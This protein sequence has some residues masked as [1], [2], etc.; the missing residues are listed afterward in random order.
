MDQEG[1]SDK[2]DPFER[3]IRY[4]TRQHKNCINILDTN[5]DF[6]S[7]LSLLAAIKTKEQTKTVLPKPPPA[8]SL[9]SQ[10]KLGPS[11]GYSR[12]D[13]EV[14][15]TAEDLFNIQTGMSFHGKSLIRNKQDKPVAEPIAKQP[16]KRPLSY[17][18]SSSSGKPSKRPSRTPIILIPASGTALISIYNAMDILQDLRFVTTEEKKKQMTRRENELLIQ[19]RKEGGQTVPYRIV[20]NPLRLTEDEWSRV[21]AVFVQGPAWQF[22]GWH[23]GGNPTEIFA[24]VCGFHLKYEDTKLDP[25][26]ARWSVEVLQLSKTKR[27]LDKAIFIR[28]WQ[29]IEQFIIR[30][31]HDL[32]Y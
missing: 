1:L 19:R 6:S 3:F 9:Q 2:I 28:L 5:S 20:D 10:Q 18:S 4:K 8:P 21:V 32:R 23:W 25:N 30:N 29:K 27:H 15:Q 17:P 26:V 13:Q 24:H 31:K 16:L 7:V 12:Y 22:K 14:F 11:T